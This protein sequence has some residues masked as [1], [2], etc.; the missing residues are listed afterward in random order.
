MIINGM[1]VNY[2]FGPPYDMEIRFS[3][4][5][6]AQTKTT[7]EKCDIG[8]QLLFQLLCHAVQQLQYITANGWCLKKTEEMNQ[9]EYPTPGPGETL[10]YV[11]THKKPILVTHCLTYAKY[12]IKVDGR[13]VLI[14]REGADCDFL[15]DYYDPN[16]DQWLETVFDCAQEHCKRFGRM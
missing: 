12:Q 2:E 11:V 13:L 7:Y 16:N 6:E 5:Y 8:T 1:I 10:K 14:L 9:W 4:T 3:R 15:I